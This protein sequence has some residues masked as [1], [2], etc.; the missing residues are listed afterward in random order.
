MDKKL[1]SFN[2]IE[3]YIMFVYSYVGKVIPG[4]DGFVRNIEIY[5]EDHEFKDRIR[6]CF[7]ENP[8]CW[9]TENASTVLKLE[10]RED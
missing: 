4:Y 1:V 7:E 10:F 9:R 8:T 3:D 2:G 5:G 6:I